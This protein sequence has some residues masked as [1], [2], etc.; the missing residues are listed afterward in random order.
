MDH[1]IYTEPCNDKCCTLYHRDISARRTAYIVY[2]G[3][4][5]VP[6]ITTHVQCTTYISAISA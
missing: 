3:L 2:V 1:S 6:G 5:L 4:C